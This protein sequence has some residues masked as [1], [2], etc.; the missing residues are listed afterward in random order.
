MPPRALFDQTMAVYTRNAADRGQYTTLAATGIPCRLQHV[1]RQP[2]ATSADRRDLAANR[3][4]MFDQSYILP[5][6]S[7][8]EVTGPRVEENRDGT[9]PARWN[10]Q[11]GTL[12]I[13][14]G[15]NGSP[16]H[17]RAEVVR[18]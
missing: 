1:M 3:S 13:A 4:I 5:E 16:S 9:G 15:P 6:D 17:R 12:A 2:A 8:I 7:Q 18:A 14:Q 10:V 11:R